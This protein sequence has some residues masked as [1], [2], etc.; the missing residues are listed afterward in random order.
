VASEFSSINESRS[1]ATLAALR[2]PP[3]VYGTFQGT[4]LEFARY[5]SEQFESE[6]SLKG[7]LRKLVAMLS[8]WTGLER[9]EYF[10]TVA[11]EQGLRA[12]EAPISFPG[13][14]IF[15]D[16]SG[17]NITQALKSRMTF[18]RSATSGIAMLTIQG[19]NHWC[20]KFSGPPGTEGFLVWTARDV[21]RRTSNSTSESSFSEGRQQFEFLIESAQQAAKWLLRLDHAQALLYEDDVTGLF[22]FRYLDVALDS[23][24]RRLQRFHSPFSVLFIDIDNFKQVNDIHG[25]LVGSSTLRQV[26]AQ[27]KSA[28]RDVDV[29][30]RY[31]GDEFVVVLIGTNSTQALQAAE[32]V[33][34]QISRFGFLAEGETECISITASIGVASCPQHARDKKSLLRLADETMYAAKRSGKN[35]VIMVQDKSDKT[36]VSLTLPRG[37][38]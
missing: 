3:A 15:D 19:C 23:E 33:R 8:S 31:G 16:K 34:N 11:V 24:F 2:T 18:Q 32:R 9:V 13:H 25:H 1:A 30:I 36:A 29:V 26:G 27:I 38:K 6:V 35:R 12:E 17:Q 20:A 22:N 14:K 10:T 7:L 21:V 5:C 37:A 28:L 4:E